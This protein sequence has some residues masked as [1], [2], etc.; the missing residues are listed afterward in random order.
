MACKTTPTP[1][2][3]LLERKN[4]ADTLSP[5]GNDRSVPDMISPGHPVRTRNAR[6]EILVGRSLSTSQDG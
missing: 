4:I 5:I 2:F 3:A 6:T 1:D